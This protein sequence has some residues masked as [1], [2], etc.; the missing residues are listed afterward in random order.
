MSRCNNGKAGRIT[1]L[2][3]G[4]PVGANPGYT[5]DVTLNQAF[6]G[7]QAFGGTEEFDNGFLILKLQANNF[8]KS[9]RIAPY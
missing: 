8:N 1:R 3:R 2:S 9:G 7:R 4:M 5:D 6:A